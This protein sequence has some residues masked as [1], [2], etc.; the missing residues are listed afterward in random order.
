MTTKSYDCSLDDD[1]YEDIDEDQILSGLSA[2]ELEQLENEIDRDLF[3]KQHDV[4]RRETNFHPTLS[5][6][7][8][9]QDEDKMFAEQN[10]NKKERSDDEK[11]LRYSLKPTTRYDNINKTEVENSFSKP[12]LRSVQDRKID[13]QPSI[14][15]AEK[16]TSEIAKA[17][18]HKTKRRRNRMNSGGVRR[19]CSGRKNSSLMFPG[20]RRRSVKIAKEDR[21]D[22]FNVNRNL[23]T[24]EVS[25]LRSRLKKVKTKEPSPMADVLSGLDLKHV[26]SGARDIENPI[27]CRNNDVVMTSSSSESDYSDDDEHRDRLRQKFKQERIERQGKPQFNARTGR[28]DVISDLSANAQI[29]DDVI[30][31]IWNNDPSL[32]EVNLNN[33]QGVPVYLFEEMA[34]AMETNTHVTSLMLSNTNLPDQVARCLARMLSRNQNLHKLN[35]ESNYITGEGALRIMRSA[36]RCKSL[37]EIRIDNQRHLFGARVEAEFVKL[38]KDNRSIIRFGYQFSNPGF[39]MSAANCLTKNMDDV[40]KRRVMEQR[41]RPANHQNHHHHHHHHPGFRRQKSS[42]RNHKKE[43]KKPEIDVREV[44]GDIKPHEVELLQKW[45]A[46]KMAEEAAM[47]ENDR[48][49]PV[50]PP[51]PPPPP[52]PMRSELESKPKKQQPPPKGNLREQLMNSI[53]NPPKGRN[54]LNKVKRKSCLHWYL[55]EDQDK[56]RKSF[57]PAYKDVKAATRTYENRVDE[58]SVLEVLM[59]SLI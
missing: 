54:Y 49:I 36:R 30:T 51:P 17:A 34:A 3:G 18:N 28:Y 2:Q 45:F 20:G 27:S 1:L 26:T 41:T 38:L 42:D 15:D 37:Q 11:V 12:N 55:G 53:R 5:Y 48:E 13:R 46:A 43:A 39:R 23:I 19:Y 24:E 40:R 10:K 31:R 25:N 44:L 50:P 29:V 47:K 7:I 59:L 22:D 58:V 6:S 56:T 14:D 21:S 8:D 33:I 52:P 57:I 16:M 9:E 35:L 4:Y 32:T